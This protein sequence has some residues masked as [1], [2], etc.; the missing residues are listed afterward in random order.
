MSQRREKSRSQERIMAGIKTQGEKRGTGSAV[1]TR[2]L[3]ITR[4]SK[5]MKI[6][7]FLINSYQNN[8]FQYVLQ[9]TPST[10]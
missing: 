10:W 3:T 5:D 8:H 6:Y 4:K 9:C 2:M 1:D 7:L